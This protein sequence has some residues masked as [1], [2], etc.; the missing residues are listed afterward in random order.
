MAEWGQKADKCKANRKKAKE[1]NKMQR[2]IINKSL[3]NN[4]VLGDIE[5][6]LAINTVGM[7]Y[8]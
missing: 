2:N 5:K 4:W 6:V 1:L 3:Q 7:S 8:S